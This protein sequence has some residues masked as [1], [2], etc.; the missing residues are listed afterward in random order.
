M[1]AKKLKQH[2]A[3]HKKVVLRKSY[4]PITGKIRLTQA[5]SQLKIHSTDLETHLT[6]HIVDEN[7]ADFDVC[8]DFKQL[9]ECINLFT[10]AVFFEVVNGSLRIFLDTVALSIGVESSKDFPLLPI[11]TIGEFTTVPNGFLKQLETLASFTLDGDE[12]RPIFNHVHVGPHF[13]EATN[14]AMILQMIGDTGLPEMLIHK[15][16]VSL[17]QAL[18][19]DCVYRD[20]QHDFTVWKTSEMQLITKN[21]EGNFPDTFALGFFSGSTNK[22]KVCIRKTDLAQARKFLAALL[23]KYKNAKVNLFGYASA[24]ATIQNEKLAVEIDKNITEIPIPGLQVEGDFE[25]RYDAIN[26][27]AVLSAFV[28]TEATLGIAEYR[29]AFHIENES[30]MRMILMPV[31]K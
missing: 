11:V 30:G 16:V 7:S 17:L 8:V 13:S 4:V 23:P 6:T 3:W 12:F 20:D 22:G 9:C 29:N 5:G 10:D 21:F 19:P 31:I 15:K 24:K 27:F 28:D 2:L 14:G 26:L 25:S 18:I 1:D